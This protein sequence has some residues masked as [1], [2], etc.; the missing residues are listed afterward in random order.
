MFVTIIGFSGDERIASIK[1][2]RILTG[3]SLIDAK[4]TFEAVRE[5]YSQVVETAGSS[6]AWAID[7]MNGHGIHFREP[8]QMPRRTNLVLI[9]ALKQMPSDL[10][11]GQLVAILEASL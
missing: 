7:Y 11:V 3:Q 2:L 1:A 6:D 8:D 9:N 5:G 4:R 10:T